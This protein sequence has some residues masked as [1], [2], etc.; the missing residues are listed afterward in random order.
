MGHRVHVRVR[1]RLRDWSDSDFSQLCAKLRLS[2]MERN[3][4]RAHFLLSAFTR[5]LEETKRPKL[6]SG[7]SIA[8]VVDPD[9][10]AFCNKPA[11][12]RSV[13]FH[14]RLTTNCYAS[15]DSVRDD[16]RRRGRRSSIMALGRDRIKLVLNA[17]L[18]AA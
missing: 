8:L 7:D 16:L 1:D 2:L 11:T 18:T 4:E 13:A 10:P 14:T 3:G 15:S 6:E 9:R 12:S 17:V 5:G